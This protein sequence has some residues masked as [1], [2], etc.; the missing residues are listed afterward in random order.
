MRPLLVALFAAVLTLFLDAQQV[1][2]T[3]EVRLIEVD[4]VV[5]DRNGNPVSGL[6]AAD[7]E[8]FENGRAQT[9]TNFAEYRESVDR[10]APA[11]PTAEV[12]VAPPA[13][14]TI[15]L[16]IDSLAVRANARV[17]LFENLRT[18]V[19]RTMREGDRAQ[20][21]TWH[22]RAG[23][24]ATTPLT[25]DRRAIEEAIRNA[26]RGLTAE[27]TGPTVEEYTRFFQQ[28]AE[29]DRSTN[30]QAP[31]ANVDASRRF[32]ADQEMAIMRRKTAAMERIVSSL[33]QP[34]GKSVFVYVSEVF[35]MVAGKR[36]LG[37]RLAA[38]TIDNRGGYVTLPLL[39]KVIAAANA[40]GVSF[41]G[42]RAEHPRTEGIGTVDND[43][44]VVG[45][46]SSTATE[47]A[48]EQI[49]LQNEVDALA[50]VA[51]QTG[52][53]IGIGPVG[54]ERAIE[55]I[56]RDVTSYYTLAYRTR[57]D[58]SDRERRIEVRAKSP[59]HV[60][61]TRRTI[62]EK[63]DR[64]RLRELVVA[65]LFER[66]P[67]GDL[68]FDVKTGE[69]TV[70]HNSKHV[71]IPVELSIPAEE[72]KFEQEGSELAARF[73]V[74]TVS[75][76]SL[77]SAGEVSEESKRITAPV[78]TQPAGD[79]KFRFSVRHDRKPA[80]LSIA[81]VDEKTQ[82]AGTRQIL[83]EGGKATVAAVAP[84][85]ATAATW[86][87]AMTRAASERKPILV[88]N[89]PKR[90]GACDRFEQT[91]IAH[92]A[93]QRRLEQL[94][95]VT[96]PA[97]TV[98]IALFDRAGKERVR[99]AD[100]PKTTVAFGEVLD[101]IL[102]VA[103]NLE[104]AVALSENG[105]AEG[106]LEAAIAL[107]RLGRPADARAAIARAAESGSQKTQQFAVIATAMLDSSE[108]K[109]EKALAALDRLAADAMNA[110]VAANA[111]LGMATIHRNTKA[112]DRAGLAYQTA[113][114]IAGEGTELFA[115]AQQALASLQDLVA[116][117]RGP[118]KLIPLDRRI[119]TGRHTVRTNV[120]SASVARVLF[121]IDGAEPRS[122]DK[123][124]F[125]T[126]YD[127]GRVPQTHT[128]R[129][130]AHD[131]DGNELGRDEL[132]V[133]DAGE[134]FWLRLIEPAGGQA[135]GTV[136]VNTTVRVPAGRKVRRVAISWN[137]VE[138][139]VLSVAPWQTDVAI[140]NE[141]G[142][143]R[144][145]VE[146][147]DGRTTEDAVLLNAAGHVERADVPLVEL[148]IFAAG[149]V[150]SASE[151]IVREGKTRRHVEAV[152]SG[153]DAPLTV[154]IVIDASGS[155]NT[156]LPDV[157]EAAIRFLETALGQKDRAFLI[158]FDTTARL[159][160][161]P[162]TDR[163]L[164]RR[165]IMAIHPNGHT[166]LN[167]AMILGLLQFEGVKGRRGMIVFS[168]GI[169]SASRYGA[170]DVNDLAR[171]ANIPLY[172]IAARSK[173]SPYGLPPPMAPTPR[174]GGALP[175]GAP[176]VIMRGPANTSR[177]TLNRLAESSGG[178][179]HHLTKLEALPEIYREIEADLRAQILAIIRTDAGKHEN[180]W[181]AIEVDVTGRRGVRAPSGY[182]A[183]W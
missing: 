161:P 65:R 115:A 173:G 20:V 116:A 11:S 60:I 42:L 78:G 166:A 167:D 58:G 149:A 153:A 44:D 147:D 63:S 155:M 93:I 148:P 150:P 18:L 131:R 49:I 172:V 2:E 100:L 163:E 15:V 182:Y 45:N 109:H 114:D 119:V 179:M 122:V 128:I 31:S 105:P 107:A 22:D 37:R 160:Q 57:S 16:F 84:S 6:T 10:L 120:A 53:A 110:E 156:A 118:I 13:P 152:L 73:S 126:T 139:K 86:G 169:D 48:A 104:R 70:D 38:D 21:L 7:F 41:Y 28:A 117:A 90:C 132:A 174:A 43:N 94:V 181:R 170:E 176:A 62:V 83:L 81:V 61:R 27:A 80:T 106:E 144:A 113:S 137:D 102:S 59:D 112:L 151:I 168:D 54:V 127:F 19:A 64:T 101:V 88:L 55:R 14:R 180:D 66:G 50:A 79:I 87:G 136:R 133:N 138:Q 56:T 121:T 33:A 29:M 5:I 89:R 129:V 17:K 108:G 145:V 164:L 3:V 177:T 141:L 125:S 98:S 47:A 68:D 40:S 146:L 96:M 82:L 69:W 97:E 143:L 26:E 36:A 103:P 134:T 183:P 52:G 158:T 99:W 124:P 165:Q 30:A 67:A 154:G 35:P 85:P 9:I 25:S 23:V 39:E 95:F 34:T 75:G 142:V 130:V 46:T 157:Q 123:P 77:Q 74:M 4:A 159:V 91:T 135:S 1:S 72:L 12:R 71:L 162:T 76:A 24:T 171:R 175:T 32:A 92:P 8:L 51:L 111:W 178:Q 140:P